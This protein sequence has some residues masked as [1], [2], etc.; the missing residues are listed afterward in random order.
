MSAAFKI[1]KS[2]FDVIFYAFII[3][4]IDILEKG[5]KRWRAIR[6]GSKFIFYISSFIGLLTGAFFFGFFLDQFHKDLLSPII[7]CYSG[8]LFSFVLHRKKDVFVR[9][10]QTLSKY[11][12]RRKHVYAL[13]KKRRNCMIMLAF[14]M[15]FFLIL[16]AFAIY[17]SLTA[18]D[19]EAVWLEYPMWSSILHNISPNFKKIQSVLV[20]FT[21]FFCCYLPTTSYV[22][23]FEIIS[24]YLKELLMEINTNVVDS[25]YSI[26]SNHKMYS[27]IKFLVE[28]V[29]SKLKYINCF[30]V[31]NFA[32]GVYY[33]LFFKLQNIFHVQLHSLIAVAFI[34]NSAIIAIKTINESG[35]IPIIN[36]QILS[37][38]SQLPLEG[39]SHSERI[40]FLLQIQQGLCLTVGGMVAVTKGWSLILLGSILTY[41]LLIKSI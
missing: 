7:F 39:N 40:I 18:E 16:L 23:A 9:I 4:G 31:L 6:L 2:I 33:G 19:T 20:H 36:Q 32:S 26:K 21:S 13:N 3:S 41:S 11:K 10:V 28:F 17:F 1:R 5:D 24:Y 29:D 8:L 12:M 34:I 14:N 38:I 37:T 15:I 27:S 22:T 25:P 30:V 35:E